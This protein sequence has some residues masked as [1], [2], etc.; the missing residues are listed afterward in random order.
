[1]ACARQNQKV[2]SGTYYAELQDNGLYYMQCPLG[3]K[4][5]T[6]L[7]EQKFEVLFDMGIYAIVD[8]YYREAVSAFAAALERFHEFFIAVICNKHGI[9]Q[10]IFEKTWKMVAINPNA[11]MELTSFII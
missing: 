10:E 2:S 8:G 11:N 6:C 5:V 9:P 3:H 1:M 7:Q 4:T